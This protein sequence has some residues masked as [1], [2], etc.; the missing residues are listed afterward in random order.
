MHK[1]RP[2]N[3][4]RGSKLLRNALEKRVRTFLINSL[5]DRLEYMQNRKLYRWVTPNLSL[6]QYR[7]YAVM[8]GRIRAFV[9][10]SLLVY[11]GLRIRASTT[12]FYGGRIS[13]SAE[14]RHARYLLYPSFTICPI[15]PSNWSGG[16][17][18]NGVLGGNSIGIFFHLGPFF[19]PNF[20]PIFEPVEVCGRYGLS[21]HVSSSKRCL[22]QIFLP[23]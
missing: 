16:T 6:G 20:G 15:M 11:F 1:I 18:L 10:L 23:I 8:A 5:N 21:G 2:C 7:Q 9:Y 14:K 3:A 19:G 13:T 22:S 4:C 12:K 17:Y